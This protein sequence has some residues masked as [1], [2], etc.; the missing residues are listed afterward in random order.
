LL[1]WGG[2]LVLLRRLS[3]RA[4][5]PQVPDLALEELNLP[6]QSVCWREALQFGQLL[7]L[8]RLSL[9]PVAFGEVGGEQPDPGLKLTDLL[10]LTGKLGLGLLGLASRFSGLAALHRKASLDLTLTIRFR[11]RS[12][13]LGRRGR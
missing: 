10:R 6:L 5:G 11:L 1:L 7:L 12:R 3:L 8:P 13:A 9:T 4:S 2:G